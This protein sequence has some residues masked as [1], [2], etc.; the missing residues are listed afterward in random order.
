MSH[1]SGIVVSK[2]LLD[3]FGKAIHDKNIRLIKV[4]IQ[5]ETQLEPVH[6]EPIV[7][8]WEADFPKIVSQLDATSPCYVLYRLDETTD[9]GFKWLLLCYVPDKAKVREKMVYA[10][11]RATLKSQLGTGNFKD[12]IFGTVVADFSPEGY[13]KHVQMKV[14]EVPL[15]SQE[16]SRKE[17]EEMGVYIGG[18][19]AYVHGVS[20]PVDDAVHTALKNL[21]NGSVNYVQMKIEPEKEV[22]YLGESGEVDADSLGSKVSLTEPLFHIYRWDHESDEQEFKS[23]VFIYS[24]PDG[25]G[26]TKPAPVKL[27]MLYSSSKANAEQIAKNSGIEINGKLEVNN[28]NDLTVTELD[29]ILHPKKEEKKQAFSKPKGPSRGGR[30]LISKK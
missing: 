6:S 13:H 23:F 29:N 14:A 1:S 11:T 22:I 27:R 26:G 28:Q 18:G 2:S 17:E 4:Q 25:S 15:T 8:D 19:G 12:E 10:S 21:K 3:A 24:C 5:N 30:R 20:F 9:T 7:G 16:L